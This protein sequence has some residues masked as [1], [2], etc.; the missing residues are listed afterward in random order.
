MIPRYTRYFGTVDC[1]IRAVIIYYINYTRYIS[2]RAYKTRFIRIHKSRINWHKLY[3]AA[4]RKRPHR[5][6]NDKMATEVRGTPGRRIAV[7]LTRC[8]STGPMRRSSWTE[9]EPAA[10]ESR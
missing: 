1:F 5:R 2:Q 10:A 4:N 3:A 6:V 7:N 9:A 8:S